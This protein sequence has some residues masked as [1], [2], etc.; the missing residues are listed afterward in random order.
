MNTAKVLVFTINNM[1]P[2]NYAHV[3]ICNIKRK[4]YKVPFF[5]LKHYSGDK[6]L[7]VNNEHL[8]H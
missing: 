1:L 5:C 6:S 7:F 8:K 3:K 2:V 4:Y